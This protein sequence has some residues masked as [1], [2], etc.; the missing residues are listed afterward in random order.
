MKWAVG[1][2]EPVRSE[3]FAEVFQAIHF[4]GEVR[5]VGLHLYRTAG[6][7]GTNLDQLLTLW[8]FEEGQLG[9]AR[10][11]V[12][13]HFGEAENFEIELHR[14]IEVV[15]AVAGV[16]KLFGKTHPERIAARCGARQPCKSACPRAA[17]RR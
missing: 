15:D 7:K 13:A 6:G 11:F 16:E 2:F 9:T 4:E 17:V 5:E 3:V 1:I 8:R 14:A 12:P 10:R